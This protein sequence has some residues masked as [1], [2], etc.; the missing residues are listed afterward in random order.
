MTRLIIA[1]GVIK[2]KKNQ[3][4]LSEVTPNDSLLPYFDF[5]EDGNRIIYNSQALKK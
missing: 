5:T 3:L 1:M 2:C 4:T